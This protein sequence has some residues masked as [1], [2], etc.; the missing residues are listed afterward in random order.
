V[1]IKC[2]KGNGKSHGDPSKIHITTH[3]Y[4]YCSRRNGA[5]DRT[6]LPYPPLNLTT[7]CFSY[8][9]FLPCCRFASRL[10]RLCCT[11][12]LSPPLR[13]G[14]N[15]PANPGLAAGCCLQTFS[16]LTFL[17]PM[18]LHD[19][20]FPSCLPSRRLLVFKFFNFVLASCFL[21]EFSFVNLC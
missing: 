11:L 21:P 2:H 18:F 8:L 16:C 5:P 1:I 9:Y 3:H 19:F 12:V 20:T 7:F 17:L 10:T 6:N 15:A 4:Q 13:R 14:P